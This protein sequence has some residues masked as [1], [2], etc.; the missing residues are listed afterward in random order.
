V[1]ESDPGPLE[2]SR[3]PAWRLVRLDLVRGGV[4]LDPRKRGPGGQ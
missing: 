1:V 3:Q 4:A 2:P